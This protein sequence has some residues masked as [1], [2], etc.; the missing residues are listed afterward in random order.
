MDIL[1]IHSPRPWQG[2]LLLACGL[3]PLA[4]AMEPVATGH[5]AQGIVRVSLDVDRGCLF[6]S[7]GMPGGLLRPGQLDFG[8]YPRLD[9]P[10]TALSAQLIDDEGLPVASVQCNPEVEY[11]L[12]VDAGQHAGVGDTRYLRLVSGEAEI[13]YRLFL[14]A[15]RQ[16]PLDTERFSRRAASGQVDLSLYASVI[17]QASAPRAGRYQDLLRMTLTW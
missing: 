6:S 3:A 5:G 16:Q 15:A 10:G 11:Q 2:L 8:H 9:P 1:G 13:P 17:P 7:G 12:Q 4:L 14:D